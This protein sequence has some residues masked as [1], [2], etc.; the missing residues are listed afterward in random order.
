MAKLCEKCGH[1]VNENTPICMFCGAP[2]NDYTES[3]NVKKFKQNELIENKANNFVGGIKGFGAILLIIGG[4]L[5]LISI[6]TI[7]TGEIESSGVLSVI[8]T[9]LFIAGI[10]IISNVR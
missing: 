6:I 9:I 4:L 5:D 10:G 7:V 3:E 8:G 1:E 2:V